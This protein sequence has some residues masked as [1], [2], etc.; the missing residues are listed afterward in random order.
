[1][2]WLYQRPTRSSRSVSV[3]MVAEKMRPF[4]RRLMSLA[5]RPRKVDRGALISPKRPSGGSMG[6]SFE[7]EDCPNCGHAEACR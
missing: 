5:V 3:C 1:M 7:P 6:A 2:K 4:G